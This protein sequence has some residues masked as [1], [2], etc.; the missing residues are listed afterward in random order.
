MDIALEKLEKR[1]LV[2]TDEGKALK[3]SLQDIND[4]LKEGKKPTK[5]QRGRLKSIFR[6]LWK[7]KYTIAIGSALAYGGYK[8]YEHKDDILLVVQLM[9][10]A[11]LG[12]YAKSVAGEWPDFFD[13]GQSGGGGGGGGGG[14][15]GGPGGGGG[16]FPGFFPGSLPWEEEYF[17]GPRPGGGGSY[18][19]GG[20]G[21]FFNDPSRVEEIRAQRAIEATAPNSFIF[22]VTHTL[23]ALTHSATLTATHALFPLI[24]ALS[25]GD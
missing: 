10:L 3:A 15:G 16:G 6:Y 1:A 18:P 22:D 12:Y 20:G 14:P 25:K 13:N 17:N 9:A 23:A 8:V 7:N 19:L 24:D 4:T 21:P 5:K 11:G 2:E